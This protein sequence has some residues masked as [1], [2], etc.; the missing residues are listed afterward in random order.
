MQKI[1]TFN[2]VF[3]YHENSISEKLLKQYQQSLPAVNQL[4]K[5]SE[6]LIERPLNANE[7]EKL[8][9]DKK[10]FVESIKAILSS[11]FMFPDSPEA[12]N[13]SAIGKSYAG[14]DEAA[15]M[16]PEQQKF[17]FELDEAGNYQLFEAEINRIKKAGDIYSTNE[18][19]N[20]VMKHLQA[21]I[22]S[23]S[24]LKATGVYYDRGNILQAFRGFLKLGENDGFNI[25]GMW[26]QNIV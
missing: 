18:N 17:I 4:K 3:L 7:A 22:E 1:K 8:F 6:K 19:Q 14:F 21:I 15:A 10:T 2:P 16:V 23:F 26:I 12:F 25:N 9:M 24:V 5:E 20:L 11:K 13:L